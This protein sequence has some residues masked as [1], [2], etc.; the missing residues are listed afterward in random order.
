[1][2]KMPIEM[3]QSWRQMF[4]SGP[5][6]ENFVTFGYNG[7]ACQSGEKFYGRY[8][9]DGVVL[10]QMRWLWKG[11]WKGGMVSELHAIFVVVIVGEVKTRE[12]TVPQFH[13]QSLVGRLN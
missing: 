6:A 3:S 11:R 10:L 12:A 9:M 2:R 7:E 8:S 4:H 5:L 1:M 13:H